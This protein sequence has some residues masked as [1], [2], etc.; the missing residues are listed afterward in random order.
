[1]MAFLRVCLLPS[2]HDNAIL[3]YPFRLGVMTK[4]VVFDTRVASG[5]S[6]SAFEPY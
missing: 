6:L 2:N 3:S 4:Y 5:I 1:M